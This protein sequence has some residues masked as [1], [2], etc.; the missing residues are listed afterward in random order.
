MR[1]QRLRSVV[2]EGFTSIQSAALNLRDLNV[3]VGANGAG[4]SNFIRA[5]GLLG[6]IV[7]SELGL[8]VGLSGGA[9]A[10]LSADQTVPRR[11]HLEVESDVGGYSAE[12]APRQG[13]RS[14]SS[15]RPSGGMT[16]ARQF[17]SAV[18]TGR[19]R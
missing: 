17:R 19:Q 15:T 13:M 5:L 18:A 11:I 2:V 3:L 7:D 1:H 9:N 14:S 4:K 16:H 6:R 10:L 12:L 8:Y